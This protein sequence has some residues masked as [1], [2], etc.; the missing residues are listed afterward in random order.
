MP[1]GS[2]PVIGRSVLVIVATLLLQVTVVSDLQI[3]GARPDLMVLLGLAA[4]ITTGR[5][6]GAAYGFA[7]GLAYDLVLT[8]PLG[9]SALTYALVGHVAGVAREAVLRSAWWIPVL[10][11]AA[12]SAL[13]VILY[14]VFGTVV[15]QETRGFPLVAILLVVSAVNA[16]LSPLAFRVMGWVAGPAERR[17]FGVAAG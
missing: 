11:A 6:R 12:G 8:T 5:E 15:G 2:L 10:T 4:G 16:V 7:A 9:L 13:G 1:H 3:A 14:V 17:R